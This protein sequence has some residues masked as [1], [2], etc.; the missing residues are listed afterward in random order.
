MTW[1]HLPGVT[2]GWDCDSTKSHRAATHPTPSKT[3]FEPTEPVNPPCKPLCSLQPQI[4]TRA[5]AQ[6]QEPVRM[7]GKPGRPGQ[8]RHRT[9]SMDG[10]L[11]YPTRLLLPG[12]GSALGDASV[13]CPAGSSPA[14]PGGSFVPARVAAERMRV[15][16]ARGSGTAGG[17]SARPSPQKTPFHADKRC[18]PST[19]PK[20]PA[21][22][23]WQRPLEI[24]LRLVWLREMTLGSRKAP[25]EAADGSRGRMNPPCASRRAGAR[26]E[27][28][29]KASRALERLGDR[30]DISVPPFP[31]AGIDSGGD[32]R[33]R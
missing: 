23:T 32:E 22:S 8:D 7:P 16:H 30:R 9:F 15:C 13:P 17:R 31:A 20:L 21:E 28:L 5:S 1:S 26:S 33:S 29:R 2:L 6:P 24:F 3:S 25:G 14:Q 12:T 18:L 10:A 27:G 19:K 11:G 4:T